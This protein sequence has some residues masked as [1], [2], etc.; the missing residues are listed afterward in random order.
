M[1]QGTKIKTRYGKLET[2]SEVR[3]CQV[4]TYENLNGWYHITKVF[5]VS[6]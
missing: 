2:V 4:F 3:G 1:K 5:K 6:K